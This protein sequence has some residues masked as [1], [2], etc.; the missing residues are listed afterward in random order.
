M[1]EA[2]VEDGVIGVNLPGLGDPTGMEH[3]P[4]YSS[5]HGYPTPSPAAATPF[6]VR[7]IL[8]WSEQTQGCGYDTP[9]AHLHSYYGYG[10]MSP[11]RQCADGL[12]F[13]GSNCSPTSSHPGGSNGHMLGGGGSLHGNPACLYGSGGSPVHHALLQQAGS[14]GSPAVSSALYSSSQ[15]LPYQSVSAALSALHQSHGGGGPTSP[16]GSKGYDSPPGLLH[17]H[18]PGAGASELHV[19]AIGAATGSAMAAAAAAAQHCMDEDAM[20]SKD[21]K[22]ILCLPLTNPQHQ[23]SHTHLQQQHHHTARQSPASQQQQQTQQKGQQHPSGGSVTIKTEGGIA[24]GTRVT[25]SGEK[26]KTPSCSSSE[27][28]TASSGSAGEGGLLKQ[29]QKRKPRVLFSQAQVYELER[30]FKQQRY[31]SAPE[32]EQMASGLKLT[33]TQVKIWFQNRRYKCKRQRQ[34]KSLELGAAMPAR[35]VAVPVL[36]KDGRPCLT[37]PPMTHYS[38]APYNV[39][40]FTGYS[41]VDAY[42]GVGAPGHPGHHVSMAPVN[43]IQQGNYPG[44]QTYRRNW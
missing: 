34:D 35:R 6:L 4:M 7:D 17:I 15:H 26:S 24:P 18:D 37:Q 41:T 14:S 11:P 10:E 3:L 30:R 40:P 32:R 25:G 43:Q 5:S 19:N 16:T 8:N 31:L 29:R 27:G 1:L 9:Y 22:P 33:S 21:T 23:H 13:M 42:N 12:T 2:T 28:S 36:V 39:N 20:D 38:T 44:V